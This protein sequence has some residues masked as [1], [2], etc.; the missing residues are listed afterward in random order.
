M[1]EGCRY[2]IG[3]SAANDTES[4]E[5]DV[6][7]IGYKITKI[8]DFYGFYYFCSMKRILYIMG[9]WVGLA[10]LA[11]C[12]TNVEP[13]ERSCRELEDID[14]LM[15][16]QPDSALKVM[17]EFAE[18]GRADSLDEFDDR[19]CQ[20][21]IS[22]LLYKNNYAQ[23]NR[24]DLLKAVDYF[25]SIDDGFLAARAHYMNGVGYVEKDSVVEAC[26]EYLKTLKI[27]ETHLRPN[28]FHRFMT[29]TYSRIGE[30]FASQFMQEPAIAC[31][32]KSLAFDNI[33]P[34]SPNNRSC[35]LLFIGKQY[36]KL[37][38][39]DSA[40][41][42][43]DEALR[44]LHDTNNAVFRD[45]VSYKALLDYDIH[46]HVEAPINDL[47]RMIAQ[48]TDENELLA[49][50]TTLGV[51]YSLEGQ[52]DSALL[53]LTPV[54][55][56]NNDV[57]RQRAVSPYLRTIYQ[58]LGDSLKADQYAVFI[59]DNE[60]SEGENKARVSILNELYQQHLQWEQDR[61]KEEEHRQSVRRNS[62][63]LSA[64]LVLL[65]LSGVIIVIS[66][67]KAKTQLSAAQDALKAKEQ[68]A[69]FT[70]VTAIYQDKLGN[71]AK[72]I[73]EAFSEVHS[74]A[75]AKL[76]ASY[77]DLT[78]TEVDICVLSH[79]AFR[80]KE[81][82]DILELRENT[83]AKHRSSI[84]KKTQIEAVKDLMQRFI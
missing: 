1:I 64:I 65:L 52:Y 50:Y 9:L 59:A 62:L 49:R 2:D 61:A 83:V 79:F 5:M 12:N 25:D 43:F 48:A 30:L 63:I 37:S 72:R 36:Y 60:L 45:L 34:C 39:S 26:T 56:N 27:M 24:E 57:V 8:I 3:V 54:Y 82:A 47:K 78:D 77:S 44:Q 70:K 13:V 10:M 74:D 42:Y 41:Y 16:Q 66:R 11:A 23:T 21:L 84:K 6:L 4:H 33:E 31:F 51:I 75:I 40:E 69:L 20:L 80:V 71:K 46:H 76:K 81:I 68:D 38:Q 67:R 17:L 53:Y 14:S 73:F 18:S 15:W 58:N 7:I 32:K 55:E 28:H 22:E 19:Y 29:L 35:L